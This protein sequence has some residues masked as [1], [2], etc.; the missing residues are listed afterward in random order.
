M[1]R[2]NEAVLQRL[3]SAL[4]SPPSVRKLLVTMRAQS[5]TRLDLAVAKILLT[6]R[7]ERG[8]YIT[9]DRPDKHVLLILEK[10]NVA[11]AADVSSVP[12]PRPKRLVIAPGIFSPAIFI[13]EMLSRI[14]D[15]RTGAALD[16]EL[17]GMNFLMV[18]N[19]SSLGVYNGPRGI[20]A[21]FGHVA[22]FLDR[23]RTMRFIAVAGRDTLGALGPGARGFFNAEVSIPDEWLM[24]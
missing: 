1:T 4:A 18:D 14:A 3:R 23:Y 10:H 21:C 7:G 12:E 20:D 8:I 16:A 17:S 19:L 2:Q 11:A 9:I 15:A 6:E 13:G 5:V 22:M 24:D